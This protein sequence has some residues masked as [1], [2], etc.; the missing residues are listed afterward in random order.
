MTLALLRVA[1]LATLLPATVLAQSPR[2]A[3]MEA[4]ARSISADQIREDVFFLASD[5]NMGRSTLEPG[6]DSA[7]AYVA[8]RLRAL[9]ITPAGDSGGYFQHYTVISSRV[10]TARAGGMIGS[11]PIHY[12]EHFVVQSFLQAGMHAGDVVYVG[13]GARIPSDGIDPYAGLDVA[14]KWLLV[15]GLPDPQGRRPSDFGRAGIT[16]S[17]VL[18]EATQRGARGIL[19]LPNDAF[20]SG[21]SSFRNRVPAGRDLTPAKGRA[22]AAYPL[23]RIVLSREAAAMLLAD[24]PALAAIAAGTDTTGARPDPFELGKRVAIDLVGETTTHRPYHGGG[25][26]EGSA[27]GLKDQWSSVAS[28]LDGAIGR[29]V[30]PEGDSIYN[31]ADDNASGSAV[32]LAVAEALMR[33]PRPK[34]SVLLI[35]DSGEEIGLWGSMKAPT[36]PIENVRFKI[37]VD[38][39]GRTKAPGSDSPAEQDL[40]GPGEVWVSGP[41]VISTMMNRVLEAARQK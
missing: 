37:N 20:I 33:G 38:M 29:A 24:A 5:A 35:W 2:V 17:T 13:H 22:Y 28:P 27:P 41:A 23:P 39:I 8:R 31:A 26:V 4:A 18:E 40:A 1:V 34:R 32:D 9:G 11:T 21:W 30:T 3:A 19:T 12:G 15:D 10:D 16:Y 6:Y 36:V 7:A 14:G 25:F